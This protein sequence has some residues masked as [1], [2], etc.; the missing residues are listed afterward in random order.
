MR[1]VAVFDANAAALGVDVSELMQAAGEALAVEAAAMAGGGQFLILCG[2]G[3]NGG[4]GFAAALALADY[5]VGVRLVVSG[6]S[7]KGEAAQSFR[8]RFEAADGSIEYWTSESDYGTPSLVIDCLLGAGGAGKPHGRVAKILEWARK[9]NPEL[10][11]AC[12]IPTGLGSDAILPADATVTFHSEKSG[13][14]YSEVGRLIIAPLP[15]P[16]GTTDCGPG[17]ALRYPPLDPAAHK[18][19][20][21]RL[22]IIGGG[23]FHGAPILAGRAAARVGCDLVHIAMPRNAT[24]RANWPDHLISERLSDED[25]LE[26]RGASE[27][28]RLL[29]EKKFD[30][31]VIGPGLGRE[32]ETAEEVENFLTYFS[33]SGI[34]TVVDADAIYSLPPGKWPKGLVGV[35]TP[36]ARELRMWLWDDSPAS[37]LL[38]TEEVDETTGSPKGVDAE[39]RV[40][41]RTGPIDELHGLEGRFCSATG[42]HPRMATGGTGDL[43]AGSIGGLLAQGM[44]PWPAARLACYLMRAAGVETAA[45]FGPGLLASDVPPHLARVLSEATHTSATQLSSDAARRNA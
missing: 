41:V 26:E 30:A 34:P 12:D 8:E 17:D 32:K 15:F 40:I 25:R 20:R 22:L 42:G 35:A 29:E 6:K 24:D 1:E 36:H 3:N 9:G 11:L 10:V 27:I 28:M 23:P 19:Q 18:G 31:V 4:D 2:P 13:M 21:G 45:E 43:L 14:K 44:A 38:S 39:S 16:E 5:D 7:Q 37:A 33:E